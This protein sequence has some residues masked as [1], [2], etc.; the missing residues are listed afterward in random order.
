M[1]VQVPPASA[2]VKTPPPFVPAWSV[3]GVAGLTAS[4]RTFGGGVVSPVLAAVK[5]PPEL[6]DLKTPPFSLLS[7]RM[8][9][10]RPSFA[11]LI[12]RNPLHR[13]N[14][15]DCRSM[16]W[17]VCGASLTPQRTCSDS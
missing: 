8:I 11:F 5:A 12:E 2:D 1:A 14:N 16:S 15:A 10:C 13:R 6:I 7:C 3:A 9:H 17:A 4:D